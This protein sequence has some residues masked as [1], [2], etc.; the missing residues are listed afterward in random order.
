MARP[1]RE[2]TFYIALGKD[3]GR[4]VELLA[5][6]HEA[7]PSAIVR[8]LVKAGLAHLLEHAPECAPVISRE[9]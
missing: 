8:A 1:K 6:A 7:A 9:G 2:G 3:V 4:Q 5:A